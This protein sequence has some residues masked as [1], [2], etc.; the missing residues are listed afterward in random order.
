MR[1]T[2]NMM[3]LRA[4]ENSRRHTNSLA[5]LQL[6]AAT[7]L[8]I[9]KLSDDPAA[10]QSLLERKLIRGRFEAQLG[11]VQTS[12]TRLNGSVG[13]LLDAADVI[14]QAKDAALEADPSA[15]R[16]LLAVEVNQLFDRLVSIANSSSGGQFYFGGAAVDRAPVESNGGVSQQSTSEL[17]TWGPRFAAACPSA[18]SPLTF[19]TR[20]ARC[21]LLATAA[22]PFF[23]APLA[24]R[25]VQE[26]TAELARTNS[27]F[28]TRRPATPRAQASLPG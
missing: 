1:V 20:P 9:N 10:V 17:K 11:A 2:P 12:R 3:M 18:I 24:P 4:I 27:S 21:S 7:G 25:R 6:Q 28:G 19:T 13:Q 22:P 15:R 23:K 5:D 26:Q 16:D 14:T 8:R